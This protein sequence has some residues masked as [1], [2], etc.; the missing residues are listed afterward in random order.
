M[1]KTIV[2]G[3]TSENLNE[4]IQSRIDAALGRYERWIRHVDVR[5]WDAN[6]PRRSADDQHCRLTIQL[7]GHMQVIIEETGNDPYI[8]AATAADRAKQAVGRKVSKKR[9]EKSG[10]VPLFLSPKFA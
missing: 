8:I 1:I 9:G 6:G 10:G 2:T 5:L 7:H 4:V 3:R